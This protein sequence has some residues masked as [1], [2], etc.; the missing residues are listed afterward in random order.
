MAAPNMCQVSRILWVETSFYH[1]N[2]DLSMRWQQDRGT[3]ILG[4]SPVSMLRD[5]DGLLTFACPLISIIM[6]PTSN[7]YLFG[8]IAYYLWR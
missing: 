2:W 1:K 8:E 6:P 7:K 4:L 3:F 5:G